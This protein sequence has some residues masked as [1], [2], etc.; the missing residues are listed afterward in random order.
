MVVALGLA[1]TS[2]RSAAA[3]VYA[4]F[5]LV[6][7]LILVG[8]VAD[9]D[10]LFSLVGHRLAVLAPN[11]TVLFVGAAALTATVTAVL[12]LDTAVVFLTPVLVN[13]ARSRR[14]DPTP[15]VVS[16]LLLANAGS[17]LLPGSNL[18]NLIVLG[19]LH[20]SGGQFL[21][22]MAL[23]WVASVVV[24]T[25]VIGVLERRHLRS[26]APTTRSHDRAVL[27][28]GLVSVVVATAL[29]V[30]LRSPA[31]PVAAVGVVAVALR[32]S[33]RE[34]DPGRVAG[35]LGARVLVALFGIA[36]AFGTL[37]RQWHWPTSLLGQL[38]AAGTAV[39][40]AGLSILVNNLPAASLLAARTPPHPF[41]LLIGLD[42]G[43]N[44]FVTGS[45]AWVLWWRTTRQTG[46]RPPT[47]RAVLLGLVSVPLAMAAAVAL[48][49]VTG[50][51]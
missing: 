1:P 2:A 15:F 14:A 33:S 36:V 8:L 27:G 42:V 31:V 39:L 17:L 41:A 45:L 16:C 7:G 32:L 18:T 38:D 29:V 3:Q 6:A 4:P 11:G 25:A 51:S 43:P 21:H 37:G 28:V 23:P 5:V 40:G 44:L 20:L 48:V 49:S 22:R 47:S 19:H 13:A 35:V 24:T 9:G 34:L 30:V 10:G 46:A 50:P 26:S 12:N